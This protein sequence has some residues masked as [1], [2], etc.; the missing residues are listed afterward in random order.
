MK[1]S[2]KSLLLLTYLGMISCVSGA[3]L[4][5]ND[6]QRDRF[7]LNSEDGKVTYV[8]E[9]W[10]PRG[11][12][13]NPRPFPLLLMLD[14]DYAF[15]SAV[16]ISDYLQRNGEV[17]EFIVV[18]VSYEVGFGKPLAVERTRDFTPPVDSE[19]VIK[20]SETAYYRFIKDRLLPEI[21][22]RYK[23]DPTQRTLWAYSLSGAFAIW[24]NYFDPTLFEHYILASANTDFG[25]LPKL[26]QGQI[27]N[28]AEYRGRRVLFSYDDPAEIPDPKILDDAKK[29]LANK[30]VF[31]G[32]EMRLFVTHGESHASSWFVSLPA[33]L[34]FVFGSASDG[35][36][37][38]SLQPNAPV[39]VAPT[40]RP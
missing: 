12:V 34:R 15:S 24:L 35:D 9:A 25:I 17:K 4:L 10:L 40:A 22:Q 18:G 2:H 28:G 3:G 37:S 5:A 27:F 21:G 11:Y 13:A 16:Q 1:T 29:L 19:R 30:D 39:S 36:G 38:K 31:P 7:T 14:G 32:Y 20:K 8:V 33:G 26:F 6:A 23:I